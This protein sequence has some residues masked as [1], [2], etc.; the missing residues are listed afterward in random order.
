M[1]REYLEAM[2]ELWTKEEASYDGEFVKFGPSW[3]WPKPVQSHIPVLVGAANEPRV[4]V[5][6]E[7]GGQ[8][9]HHAG[10]YAIDKGGVILLPAVVGACLCRPGGAMTLLEIAV[11]Q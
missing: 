7:G 11:P 10:R 1:L 2:R 6:I 4:L 3:A 8:V 9:E 5:C